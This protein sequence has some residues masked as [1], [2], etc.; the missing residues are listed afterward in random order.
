VR[1]NRAAVSRIAR[2]RGCRSSVSKDKWH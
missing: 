1:D 2:L